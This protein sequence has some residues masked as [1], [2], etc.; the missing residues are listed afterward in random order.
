MTDKT[1]LCIPTGNNLAIVFGADQ[2]HM[3]FNSVLKNV[4]VSV[5]FHISF[6]VFLPADWTEN[7]DNCGTS[8]I[9]E[10]Y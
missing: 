5:N 10:D 3:N 6:L 4:I 8:L 7:L 9:T 2:V 1:E